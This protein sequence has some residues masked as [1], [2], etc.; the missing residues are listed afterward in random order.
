MLDTMTHAASHLVL[1]S[2]RSALAW[3]IKEQRI[4]F[5][6]THARRG[7]SLAEGDEVFLYTTRGCFRNPKRDMGRVIGIARVT[8]EVRTLE[9]PVIFDERSFTVGCSLRIEA[10]SPMRGGLVLRDL[11]PELSV[12]PNPATWSIRLRRSVLPLPPA[13]A[14]IL[15]SSLLPHLH[16]YSET[17]S[18]YASLT[19]KAAA[20]GFPRA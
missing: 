19:E 6:P 4:A 2:D 20:S 12:F 14:N 9:D 15:R 10:L 5:S 8:S 3:V 13:D 11:V 1:L 7:T 17:A 18:R 16:P